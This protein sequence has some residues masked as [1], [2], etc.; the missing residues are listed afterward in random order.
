MKC[1]TES[2]APETA[3]T[4][5]TGDLAGRINAE[6]RACQQH[7]EQTLVHA[8]RAGELLHQAKSICEHGA[9]DN[10]LVQNFSASPRTAR[11]YMQ[12]FSNRETIEPKRQSSAVLSVGGALKLLAPPT[13]I[14]PLDDAGFDK[15]LRPNPNLT[16]AAGQALL[17]VDQLGGGAD[18]LWVE[19]SDF[20]G[21]FYVSVVRSAGEGAIVEGLKGP[22]A[23]R[24]IR[25]GVEYLGAKRIVLDGER[26]E[27]DAEP[28]RFNRWLYH[29]YEDFQ[30]SRLPSG[31]ARGRRDD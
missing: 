5:P 24:G 23:D 16:P 11:V 7:G 22:I 26:H 15:L 1:I 31:N 6:H 9:W 25:F 14:E 29:A 13:E 3:L 2:P 19:P 8:I 18:I 17:F 27:A 21:H 12:L 30:D 4:N 10:W 20:A 28:L